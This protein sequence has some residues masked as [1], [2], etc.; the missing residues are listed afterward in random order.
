[1]TLR[2]VP[3]VVALGLLA[4]LAAH[5]ALYRGEHA[6]GGAYHSLLVQAAA[7]LCVGLL[8]GFS[9]LAWSG[10][11]AADGSVLAARLRDRLPNVFW[12]LPAATLWYAGAE[13]IEPHH[14]AA[15]PVVVLVGLAAA[16][17]AVLSLARGLVGALAR[18]AIAMLR[19]AFSPRAP[20]WSRRPRL[21]PTR[22]RAPRVY[23]RFVRP[24]PIAIVLCA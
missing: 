12:I 20:S 19:A 6:M 1:M 18:A 9:A 13:A 3:G 10:A 14:L 21:Q 5:A 24:P 8:I 7:A 4:S 16:A 15:S 23:R 22:R 17:W 2:K 11:R